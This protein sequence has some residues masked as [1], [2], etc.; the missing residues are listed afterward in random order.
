MIQRIQT[1]WLLLSLASWG[2]LFFSPI[3]GFASPDSGAWMLYAEAIK[4]ATGKETVMQTIPL[5][6]LFGVVQT[7]V[8]ISLFL[9]KRRVLQLRITLYTMILQLFS[10]ALIGLYVY[11]GSRMLNAG[12]GLLFM[13]IIPAVSFVFSFLAFRA[14]R[15][16]I[17]L[18]KMVDRL[19]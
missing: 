10:Y 18:L 11:Q 1:I 12:A 4:T 2:L 15:R 19:R 13:S 14:I 3:I 5:L 9:Y 17:L 6:V 16:D 8:L 7:L